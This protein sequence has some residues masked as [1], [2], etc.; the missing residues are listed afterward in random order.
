[1]LRENSLVSVYVFGCTI[2][3]FPTYSTLWTNLCVTGETSLT[4]AHMYHLHPTSY[5]NRN[6]PGHC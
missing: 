1:M 2:P 6:I 3:A 5:D 4:S